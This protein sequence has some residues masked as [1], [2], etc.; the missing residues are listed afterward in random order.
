MNFE[1]PSFF[2]DDLDKLFYIFYK[3]NSLLPKYQ[4]QFEQII[5]IEKFDFQFNLKYGITIKKD[6]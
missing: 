1:S 6:K 3:C 5:C 4:W 2:L